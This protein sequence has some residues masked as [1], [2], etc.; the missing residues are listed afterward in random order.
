MIQTLIKSI[1]R[2]R[3]ITEWCKCITDHEESEGF[4]RE[5]LGIKSATSTSPNFIWGSLT[6][7]M[8]SQILKILGETKVLNPKNQELQQFTYPIGPLWGFS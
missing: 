2:P 5:I 7:R 4:H 8:R 3:E 1:I 6:V